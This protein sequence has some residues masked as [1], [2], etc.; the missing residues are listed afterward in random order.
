MAIADLT[1]AEL[2]APRDAVSDLLRSLER[3]ALLHVDDVHDGLAEELAQWEQRDAPDTAEVDGHLAAA[4]WILDL[5]Q[6]FAPHKA[7]ML[8]DFFG[9]PPAVDEAEFAALVNSVD[10]LGYRAELEARLADYEVLVAEL[11]A[12]RER[13]ATLTPWAELGV[14]LAAVGRG[15]YAALT[16]VRV[17]LAAVEELEG[18]LAAR[19]GH[20]RLAPVG[21]AAKVGYAVVVSLPEDLDAVGTALRQVRAEEVDLP[22][23][24]SSA[25]AALEHDR[26]RSEEL[27]RRRAE[28]AAAFADEAGQR[29]RALQAVADE[30]ESRRHSLDARGRIFYSRHAAV[31][32]GWV[33]TT[34]RGALE[35]LL[36]GHPHVR[37]RL[38]APAA[39]DRPPVKLTN[40]R[41][42]EPFQTLIT[43][44]GLPNYFGIDPTPFVAVAMTVFYA[45]A[46][47]DFGYGVLQIL[48]ASWL[49]RR[50]QSAGETRLFLT[51]FVYTGVATL[52][53]GVLTWSFFGFSPGAGGG[54]KFLGFLP[55]V[56][57]KV[58]IVPLI[59]IA[60]GVGIIFQLASITAGFVNL[61]KR[62]DRAGAICDNLAWL[63]LLVGGL[64]AIGG[65]FLGASALQVVG[66]ALAAAGA[67]TIVLFAGRDSGNIVAR[68][69]AGVVSLYGIVGYYGLVGFFSD[70]LSYMRLAI[71]NMTSAFIAFVAQ[72]IG[73]LFLGGGGSVVMAVIAAIIGALIFVFFHLLNLVLSMLGAF[74]HSL[75]LNYLESFQRY[76][77]EGGRAFTP[78]QRTGRFFRRADSEQ[79]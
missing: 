13:I 50:F 52:V 37:Y 23:L 18:L 72:V 36:A 78:F 76:Y 77:P 3:A 56:D 55:L 17:P 71:L 33:E 31:I 35:A 46:L 26:R 25:A 58:N 44:Y 11:E 22:R 65:M 61:L 67:V 5:F 40:R 29:R 15:R 30:Y 4:R 68:I 1:K 49:R 73:G 60:V 10:V 2:V 62:G 43:M 69:L 70:A 7:S 54:G 9:S 59:G 34:R 38:S 53:V 27:E 75:R 24:D 21:A 48:L 8:E 6:R 14:D 57:P 20:L 64:L 41:L 51:M 28:L 47:G 19:G 42:V 45:I 32:V 39:D 79:Q 16:P 63:V 12:L 74:V 66:A